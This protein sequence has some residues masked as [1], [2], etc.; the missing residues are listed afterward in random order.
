MNYISKIFFLI[1][2]LNFPLIVLYLFLIF[3]M[4]LNYNFYKCSLLYV[5]ELEMNLQTPLS[6][7]PMRSRSRLDEAAP[8]KLDL[9]E[10]SPP[11]KR[12][13]KK[14]LDLDVDEDNL[15]DILVKEEK[16]GKSRAKWDSAAKESLR[17][18]LCKC[19]QK[20][21]QEKPQ[22]SDLSKYLITDGYDWATPASIASKIYQDHARAA[23]AWPE[24]FEINA[25]GSGSS[26][27]RI[28]S[29]ASAKVSTVSNK[30]IDTIKGQFGPFPGL[31]TC[32]PTPLPL[33]SFPSPSALDLKNIASEVMASS[34]LERRFSL[35]DAPKSNTAPDFI[36]TQPA[37]RWQC[38]TWKTIEKKICFII[39]PPMGVK[40]NL[41]CLTCTNPSYVP[42][43]LVDI[44]FTQR[45][46]LHEDTIK[47]VN[48]MERGD[49]WKKSLI[50][51][52][53]IST[54][55]KW[56]FVLGVRCPWA[57]GEKLENHSW[58]DLAS[59]Q[60]EEVNNAHPNTKVVVV[61]FEHI[62]ISESTEGYV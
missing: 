17:Q 37:G 13:K 36:L 45:S 35:Q 61:L 38:I 31:G 19:R 51:D 15:E 49:D 3:C 21:P 44:C 41:K 20:S 28:I 43:T 29:K 24:Y 56:H 52:P 12:S 23:S 32:P 62:P 10:L 40:V 1:L 22:F 6:T 9:D 27:Q 4:S 33:A 30:A 53:Q 57:A 39:E 16:S 58:V 50:E 7:R 25:Q 11:N 2:F 26:A 5:P 18:A 59:T 47:L 46:G 48:L 54:L 42:L 8:D 60:S 34:E 14:E 55:N